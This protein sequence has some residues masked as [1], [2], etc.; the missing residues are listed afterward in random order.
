MYLYHRGF[1]KDLTQQHEVEFYMDAVTFA[2]PYTV[3][4]KILILP[5]TGKGISNLTLGKKYFSRTIRTIN[6]FSAF[7]QSCLINA[8]QR[9]TY[10]TK[11]GILYETN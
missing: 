9:Q 4:G 2:G 11:W 7:S 10:R 3:N 8:F 5:M 1:G 6:K